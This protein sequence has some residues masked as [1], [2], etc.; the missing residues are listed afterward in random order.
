MS[1]MHNYNY[2]ALLTE[3]EKYSEGLPLLD[4]ALERRADAEVDHYRLWRG[5]R[6]H[7][8]FVEFH[9]LFQDG[10]ASARIV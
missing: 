2:G 6:C 4:E 7:G 9:E 3:M 5:T 8:R 1:M 10:E